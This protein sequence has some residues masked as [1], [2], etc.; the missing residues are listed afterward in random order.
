M[1]LIAKT[2]P[3]PLREDA[4]GVI[5]VGGTRVTL[6]TV[7]TAYSRGATPEQITQD[8]SALDTADIYATIA[9][10]LRHRDEVEEYL[11]RRRLQAE[12]AR[13]NLRKLSP[14]QEGLRERLEARLR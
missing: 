11:R 14:D 5:R 4:E 6:E 10:Y 3:V 1:V 2:G 7:L 13:V 9:Y 8:Y 12:E